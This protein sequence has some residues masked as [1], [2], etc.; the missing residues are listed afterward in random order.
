MCSPVIR[1]GLNNDG[2]ILDWILLEINVDCNL[3]EEEC[4][5][6]EDWATHAGDENMVD[7]GSAVGSDSGGD[8]GDGDRDDK[9]SLIGSL[10]DKG[11]GHRGNAE[12]GG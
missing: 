5:N 4:I 10:L 1:K 8:G 11:E 6:S 12:G 9:R 3:P 7:G 2:A